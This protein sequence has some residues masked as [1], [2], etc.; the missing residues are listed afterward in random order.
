MKFSNTELISR[1]EKLISPHRSENWRLHGDVGAVLVSKSGK[2]FSG[3]CIDTPGWGI[4]AERSAIAAMVTS[5]EYVIES[6]V[7][8]WKDDKTGKLHVLPPCGTCREFMQQLDPLN[9]D[10]QVILGKTVCMTLRELIPFNNWP[11]PIE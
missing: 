8:V 3:V 11:G 10:A 2:I 1:A 5:G 7:A 4:C 6:I 9:L